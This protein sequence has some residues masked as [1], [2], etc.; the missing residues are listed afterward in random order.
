MEIKLKPTSKFCGELTPPGDKSISHR[1]AILN[2]ITAGNAIIENFSPGD[3]C[4]ATLDCLRALGV[5]VK[6]LDDAQRVEIRGDGRLREAE[7]VLNA[8]NSGTTA[9]LLCGVLAAQPFLSIITGD[10]SLRSRPMDRVIQPLKLMGAQIWGRQ[11]DSRAPLVIKGASL[12]GITYHLP[13]PSA[14]V[15]SALLLAGLFADSET[16]IIEPAPSRDHTERMLRAMGVLLGRE[17]DKIILYPGGADS[18]RS[19]SLKVPGDI[20]SAAYFLVAAAIHPQGEVRV[21]DVGI[22]YT[23]SGI[24]D[25]LKAMGAS[26]RLENTRLE[27]EEPVADIVV[28]GSHLH[29]VE[30]SGEI[31]PRAID[32]IPLI[33]VAALAAEGTTI[34]RGAQELRVKESDR[35]STL[36]RELSLLGARVEELPDGMVIHGGKRLKGG[37]VA[38]H[39]DHRIAMTLAVA[40]LLTSEG[41]TI[42]GAEAVA[43]SYPGFW[44]EWLRINQ[45]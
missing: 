45:G 30:I 13:V 35:I 4:R 25:I 38:S 37:E 15:K 7:D 5:E 27:G 34:I 14:Q 1:A 10:A 9:R 17:G 42:S 31:I 44:E 39:R 22:N 36:V 41:V 40:S 32:E 18:L 33:A 8:R 29:G 3:D 2:S 6:Y 28:V 16:V 21:R 11:N 24:L 19:L 26:I 23:R 12:K 20:S 43:V